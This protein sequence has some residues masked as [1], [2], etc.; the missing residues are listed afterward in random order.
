MANNNDWALLKWIGAIVISLL[1]FG[2]GYFMGIIVYV[3]AAIGAVI[4]LGTYMLVGVNLERVLPNRERLHSLLSFLAA[5]ISLILVL[6]GSYFYGSY[7]IPDGAYITGGRRSG[8]AVVQA[9]GGTI[10]VLVA[11]LYLVVG[12]I[13]GAMKLSE[14]FS[15]LKAKVKGTQNTKKTGLPR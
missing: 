13:A 6:W 3:Y 8:G 15:A 1:I 10:T 9:E 7:I 5:G 2:I 11:L 4:P 12:L 14:G